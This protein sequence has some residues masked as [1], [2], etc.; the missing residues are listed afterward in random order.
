MVNVCSELQT[1]ACSY[2]SNATLFFSLSYLNHIN[3][4]QVFQC[5]YYSVSKLVIK[6]YETSFDDFIQSD[7][8]HLEM[9]FMQ[10]NNFMLDDLHEIKDILTPYLRK[11]PQ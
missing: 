8:S 5:N 3:W 1:P 4:F 7:N 6:I 9:R 2:T 10:L 11:C